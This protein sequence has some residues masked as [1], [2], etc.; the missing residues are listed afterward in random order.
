[1]GFQTPALSIL[2]EQYFRVYKFEQYFRVYKF[3]Q[4]FRVYKFEPQNCLHFDRK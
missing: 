3:E 4:Y 2:P 1:M